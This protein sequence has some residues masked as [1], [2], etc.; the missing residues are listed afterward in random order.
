MTVT[1]TVEDIQKVLATGNKNKTMGETKM[2][3]NSSR[4]HCIFSLYV[5]TQNKETNSFKV[6]KINFV[7]LAGSERQ[8]KTG[9]AG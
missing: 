4:S 2:N 1:K 9:A 3:Q 8:S 7:D 6:G 5:E